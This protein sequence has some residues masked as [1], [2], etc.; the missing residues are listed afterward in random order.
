MHALRL[1]S[2]AVGAFVVALSSCSSGTTAN[3]DGGADGGGPAQLVPSSA[4]S[5]TID[6]VYGDPGALPADKGAIIKCATDKA[7]A[8]GDLL[9]AAKADGYKGK[10]FTSGAKVYR[11]LYRTERGDAKNTAGYSSAAV[12][13]PDA[14]R[15]N[16]LPVVVASHGS[17]GQA[18]KC[19][20]SKLD[21][22]TD[23]N[24][25]FR[26]QVYPLVGL[27]YAVIAPDLAGYAN[28]GAANNAIPVYAGTADVGKSTLDGARALKKLLPALSDKTVIIGHSQ[29]GHTALSALALAESYGTSGTVVG[30]ATYAPLWLS[31][32]SWGAVA[33]ASIGKNYAIDTNVPAGV[34]LWYL[35]THAEML[36]GPGEGKKLFAPAA[37]NVVD[38][39]VKTKCWNEA[40]YPY[41][42]LKALG[43]AASDL[44]DQGFGG[45]VGLAAA[46]TGN[47]NGDAVCDKWMA[48]FAE[49][50]PHLKGAAAKTPLLMVYGLADDTIPPNRITCAIDRLKTDAAN[51]TVCGVPGEGHGSVLGAK[52]EYVSDWIASLTLGGTAPAKCDKDETA[53]VDPMTMMPATCA[54]PPPND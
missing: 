28:F 34:S 25:D 49:D 39:F 27:G 7:I 53:I 36:D 24:T 20:P 14:P 23:T 16:G 50:R 10:D 48:R 21:P 42:E 32:R 26:R 11:V 29:G 41:P 38:T 37:Q 52:G 54:S 6:S 31:Q 44:Y 22:S 4:C 8:K 12:Y 51:M 46:I 5:D 33:F 1:S 19:A 15:A 47:C 18:A 30:V 43:M 45:S 17:R 9:A 40:P 2:L 35:Y 3:P 13:I